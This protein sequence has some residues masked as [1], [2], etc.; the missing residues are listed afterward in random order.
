M[1]TKDILIL[2]LIP[3]FYTISCNE[4]TSIKNKKE[5]PTKTIGY[6]QLKN[7]NNLRWYMI[8]NWDINEKIKLMSQE[9]EKFKLRTKK[10]NFI[11]LSADTCDSSSP[12]FFLN[13]MEYNTNTFF[14]I[15]K[16]IT[17]SLIKI[18]FTVIHACCLEFV[19]YVNKED[20]ILDLSYFSISYP[21]GC[22]C[23]CEYNFKF[24]IKNNGQT[25]NKILLNGVEI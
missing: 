25:F 11:F 21:G 9:K 5:N 7:M 17:D 8:K 15:K 18:D 12:E 4:D 20:K 2:L 3:F 19:G 16:N 10:D 13:L 1:K 6:S 24:N 23:F 22:S 14:N